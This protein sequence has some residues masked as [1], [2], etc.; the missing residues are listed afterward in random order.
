[1]PEG[2]VPESQSCARGRSQSPERV[3]GDPD[4]SHIDCGRQD[5]GGAASSVGATAPMGR[6]GA[7]CSLDISQKPPA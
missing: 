7:A 6:L 2:W 4:Y 3:T 5:T 1:M